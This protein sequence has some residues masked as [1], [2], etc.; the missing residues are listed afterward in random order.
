MCKIGSLTKTTSTGFTGQIT[1]YQAASCSN[2][3]LRGV[4]HKNKNNR[5]IEVNHNLNHHKAV[6]KQKLESEKGIYHRKKRCVD[7][8][9]V[10]GNVKSN[11]NFKRFILRGT[12]K[13]STETGILVIAHNLRKKTA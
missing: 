2:C 8:G 3:P 6:S 11:H 13:V 4:C 9:P 12:D 1:R 5:I 7:V 10:F